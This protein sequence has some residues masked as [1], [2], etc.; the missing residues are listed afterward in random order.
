MATLK[1]VGGA[2]HPTRWMMLPTMIDGLLGLSQNMVGEEDIPGLLPLC[3]QE[4]QGALINLG[5]N[6]LHFPSV[7]HMHRTI[8]TRRHSTTLR[9]VLGS[10]F[11]EKRAQEH[12]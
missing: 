12:S 10:I 1:G 6:K 8:E 11:G 5:T 3:F 4:K 9:T 2:A 7:A